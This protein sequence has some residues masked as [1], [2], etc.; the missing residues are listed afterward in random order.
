MPLF[1]G[2]DP[3]DE[4]IALLREERD[5]LRARVSELEK[6]VLALSSPS[7]YRLIH[8]EPAP[9]ERPSK[10]TPDAYALR[11]VVYRPAKTLEQ[12]KLGDS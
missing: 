4:V 3:K 9:S 6:Q 11:S 5:H 1:G 12:I 8:H 7:A 10:E 2:S